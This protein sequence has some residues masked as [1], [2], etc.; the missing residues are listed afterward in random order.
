MTSPPAS[1]RRRGFPVAAAAPLLAVAALALS[2]CGGT[3]D[4]SA[5]DLGP[6][7][8][9]DLPGVDLERVQVGDM[10]P[11]FT[12]GSF[13]GPAVTLSDFRGEAR[14]LLVFYRGHW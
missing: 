13:D 10:A 4:G 5:P 1:A 8:G 9:G 14:V 11:D 12:L 2:A 6:A 3:G 7:D